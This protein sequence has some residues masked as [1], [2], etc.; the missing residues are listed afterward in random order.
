MYFLASW[1]TL[2]P[3]VV[4]NIVSGAIFHFPITWR[5][6]FA[7]HSLLYNHTG[8]IWSHFVRQMCRK[9]LIIDS[10]LCWCGKYFESANNLTENL[11]SRA[12]NVSWRYLN[13]HT[14]FLVDS[15]FDHSSRP[16]PLCPTLVSS[17]S[18]LFMN[19]IR[20]SVTITQ[21]FKTLFTRNAVVS[22]IKRKNYPRGM[23]VVNSIIS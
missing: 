14:K 5:F 2:F 21:L 6:L 20:E 7:C 22:H 19:V 9:T 10:K 3:T 13:H 8:K 11:N 12:Q 17:M 16:Q 18:P 23:P 15:G 1:K 4:L